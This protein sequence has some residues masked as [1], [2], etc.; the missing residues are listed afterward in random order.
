MVVTKVARLRRNLQIAIAPGDQLKIAFR[1]AVR[2]HRH[3]A[4]LFNRPQKHRLFVQSQF[5]DLVEKQSAAIGSFEK[6]RAI[7]DSTGEGPLY[8]PE[9]RGHRGVA[10]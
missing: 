7:L 9:Q 10:A 1:F 2:T 3:E 5:C 8:M 4:F 6:S